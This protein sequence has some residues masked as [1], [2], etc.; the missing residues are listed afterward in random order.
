MKI[1]DIRIQKNGER[2]KLCGTV[3]WEDR[4]FPEQ[5]LYFETTSNYQES[6]TNDPHAFL[7][8][9]IIPAMY[10]KERRVFIDA[11]ICPE[12][13]VGLQT[14]VGWIRNWFY[15]PD[16]E[17]IRI[18]TRKLSHYTPPQRS[19]R[20][21]FLFSG[22]VD[23]L[24]TLRMNHNDYPPSHPGYIKDG[25][26]VY[27]LEIRTPES[28]AAVLET[29]KPLAEDANINLI[30]IFTNIRSMGPENNREFWSNFWLNEFMGACFAAVTHTLSNR[31]S[32]FY[33]N[34]SHDIPNIMPHS[35]H[36]LVEPNLSSNDLRIKHEG[37]ILSRY[38]KTRVISDWDMALN[39]LRVCNDFSQYALGRLNCGSCEKCLRTMLALLALGVLKKAEAF[40]ADDVTAEMVIQHVKIAKNTLPLYEELLPPL[41]EAGRADLVHAIHDRIGVFHKD[42]KR[43][44]RDDRWRRHF[45]DPVSGID[46][47][48]FGG[49]LRS[50]KHYL[51]N[52]L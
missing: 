20:A 31:F 4:D 9:C 23:S 37:T 8:A 16:S 33:I 49:K 11:E 10:Y 22:G 1:K 47:K 36:P 51:R 52:K 38:E 50:T 27:G 5:E 6:L 44:I 2:V 28:Y 32:I 12:L 30:E 39:K 18:E 42:Q 40:D 14:A 48:Y 43:K 21:G 24:S 34:S 7:T 19:S 15:G 25:V 26:L 29:L 46:Q 17:P 13:I 3:I 35:T 45:I 41:Q